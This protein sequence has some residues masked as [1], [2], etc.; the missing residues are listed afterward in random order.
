M[1]TLQFMNPAH[2]FLEIGQ[3]VLRAFN[4][5]A[6]VELPLE[7]LPDGHLTETCRAKLISHLQRYIDH[8]SWQPRPRA[9]CAV[10]ARGVSLRRLSL[11]PA[12][13]EELHRLLP[14]Q[15]ESEF[16]LP[17]DQL[18]WGFQPLNQAGPRLASN[19]AQEL[20]VAAVK[21]D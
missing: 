8:K 18:A 7:R 2:L 4:G 17:P 1:K 9:F 20:L 13:R 16:P 10:H 15:I 12:S 14:L 21:K 19:S 6:S 3:D 11:P 5:T